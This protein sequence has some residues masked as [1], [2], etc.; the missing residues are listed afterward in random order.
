[1]TVETP[2]TVHPTARKRVAAGGL[3]ATTAAVHNPGAVETSSE[4]TTR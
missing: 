3:A 2:I 1:M 4:G